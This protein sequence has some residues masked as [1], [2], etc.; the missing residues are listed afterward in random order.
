MNYKVFKWLGKRG[1]Q[2]RKLRGTLIH[3]VVG[4]RLFARDLWAFTRKGVVRGW[5]IGCLAGGS[6]FL[7]LQMLVA[8]PTALW[9]RAN[10]F[11]VLALIFVTNPITLP[12]YF[13]FCYSI[14]LFITGDRLRHPPEVM[15][16]MTGWEI[17]MSG[18]WAIIVGSLLV[19]VLAAVIGAVLLQLFFKEPIRIPR[20]RLRHGKPQEG[21]PSPLVK[22]KSDS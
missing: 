14:G 18:A 22:K 20:I 15:A 6:P 17:L 16:E 11:M 8:L 7:G 19:S 9:L 2:R 4:E 5:I 12:P 1:L 10:V 13:A 21:P 3:K